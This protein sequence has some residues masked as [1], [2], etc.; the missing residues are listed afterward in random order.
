MIIIKFKTLKIQEA[1]LRPRNI[2]EDKKTCL[3]FA[4]N[5]TQESNIIFKTRPKNR[6]WYTLYFQHNPRILLRS[7]NQNSNWK[8]VCS[9]F[10][11][12]QLQHNDI[13]VVSQT[14]PLLVII[15][16]YII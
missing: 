7:T 12:L 11:V 4:R 16:I 10:L 9:I 13:K 8:K 14:K 15:E 5:G 3:K 6:S 2:D 1:R